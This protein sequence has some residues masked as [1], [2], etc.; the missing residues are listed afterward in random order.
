MS[1]FVK[2]F[3]ENHQA[4]EMF[5]GFDFGYCKFYFSVV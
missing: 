1:D 4:A 5:G 3:S 2:V